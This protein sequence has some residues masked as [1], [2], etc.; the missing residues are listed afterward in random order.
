[1]ALRVDMTGNSTGFSQMLR[2]ARMETKEFAKTLD[3]ETGRSFKNVART[4]RDTF[5]AMAGFEAFEGVKGAV[6]WFIDSG[7]QIKDISEQLGMSTDQWQKWADAVQ[8]AGLQTEGFARVIESLKQ[9]R[10]EAL[11]DPKA[12]AELSQLG[13][14]DADISG[15]MSTSDFTRKALENAT[16]G[17]PYAKKAFDTIAGVEGVRYTRALDYLPQAQS[18]FTDEN[19]KQAQATQK[20]LHGLQLAAERAGLGILDK[21]VNWSGK[22]GAYLKDIFM[23]W[24][25][26]AAVQ[27]DYDAAKKQHEADMNYQTV[28]A[29]RNGV[30]LTPAQIAIVEASHGRPGEARAVNLDKAFGVKPKAAASQAVDTNDPLYAVL[31]QQ[32]R[33]N[34]L[35]D[36]ERNQRV[37]DSERDLMTIGDRR[38]SIMAEMGPLQKEIQARQNALS[39]PEGFLTQAQRDSLEGVSGIART[40]QVNELREKYQDEL[41]DLRTQ[42]NKDR[43]DLR[44]SPLTFQADSL[45]KVGLYSASALRFNPL[46]DIGHETNALLKQ[47]VQNTAKPSL[48]PPN[49]PHRP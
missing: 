28:R 35:R 15:N 29:A 46:L 30:A 34:A 49:D 12:R 38:R 2:K 21:F 41:A 33:D 24:K 4:L 18:V 3:D 32:L 25:S 44:Q 36:Q 22:P 13:F 9:K 14:T 40:I 16:N 6:E 17:G 19:I 20:A 37:A 47:V 48:L 31:Q 42:Y 27:A 45:A 11:T 1:M 23:P 26:K 5:V 8:Q 7:N 39:T 43:G 10:T